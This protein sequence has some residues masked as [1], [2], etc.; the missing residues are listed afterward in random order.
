MCTAAN[1][2]ARH[3]EGGRIM[4]SNIKLLK[5][6]AVHVPPPEAMEKHLLRISACSLEQEKGTFETFSTS[7]GDGD[8]HAVIKA[9]LP[10]QSS[11]N[12]AC[13]SWI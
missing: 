8:V 13:R 10:R 6:F 12:F 4:A 3:S 5:S 9:V 7:H 1:R 11:F 2:R